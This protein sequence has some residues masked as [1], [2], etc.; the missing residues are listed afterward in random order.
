MVFA[1]L[2]G[3]LKGADAV[4]LAAAKHLKLKADLLPIWHDTDADA[5]DN[6]S[7]LNETEV[8]GNKFR[9]RL[10]DTYE[11]NVNAVL[12]E[13]VRAAYSAEDIT[14]CT[15]DRRAWI[16]DH[17][18]SYYGNEPST[19]TVYSAAAIF[20]HIPAWSERQFSAA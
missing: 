10:R 3:F 1:G 6:Y 12:H 16:A 15:P 8:I 7:D 14:W 17:E 11:E 19:C 18:V 13:Q 5:D 4:V 2:A 20:M 9:F